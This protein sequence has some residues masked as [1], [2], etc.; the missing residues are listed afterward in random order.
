MYTRWQQRSVLGCPSMQTTQPCAPVALPGTGL[1]AAFDQ[2][3]APFVLRAFPIRVPL[4]GELLVKVRMCTIC[5]SDIHSYRG[6]RPSPTPGVLGHEIVGNIVALGDGVTHD[7]RGDPLRVRDRITW[8]EYF[9]PVRGFHADVL[10]L[11]HKGVGVDKYGHMAVTTPPYHHGGFG[12]YCYVLAGSWVLRVPDTLTD[13]E[14]T[15]VNCGVATMVCATEQA[16]IGLG[17]AVVVQGLGLLGLYGAALA[18]SRGARL[19]IGVDG[20]PARRALGLRFGCDHVVDPAAH[21]APALA[22]QVR[23]WCTP[24]GADVVIEVCGQADVIPTGI[25]MLR[26]GGRYVLG[27]LVSAGSLVQIDAHQIVRKLITV[28]GVHNYHPRHLL[29]ALDFVT[30]QRGR[31][32][33][34]ALVEGRYALHQVSQAMQDA[35]QRKVLRAAIVP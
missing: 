16:E 34:G 10:D 20:V 22:R 24:E 14:A 29:Q 25:D 32:P 21:D 3:N 28:R 31:Y 15:P 2:P 30:A 6:H 23:G 1:V 5:R 11:P 33:F 17:D 7:M 9:A 4:P 19:V 8:S 26:T 27:G 18:K 12:Q 13:E 35:D